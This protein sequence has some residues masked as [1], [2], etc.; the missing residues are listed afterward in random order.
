MERQQLMEGIRRGSAAKMAAL[1][2]SIRDCGS[3]LVAFSAGVDSSFVLAVARRVLG[4]RAV[5]LTAHSPSVPQVEREEARALARTLGVRHL[6]VESHEAEDPRYA[7]NPVD[8]CYYCKSELYRLC[9]AAAREHGLAAVLDGFNADDKR[10]HRPGHVA[11]SEHRVRSPLAEAGFT[12][13]EVRAWSEALG[14]PTWDKPQMACL[15]SRLPYGLAVTPERL[16]QVERAEA[17]VRAL[18]LKNFRVRYHEGIG[19]VEVAADEL[20]RAFELR[21][22]LA[23][24]VKGAGFKRAVLDLEPFRSGSLNEFAGVSLPVVA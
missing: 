12:K 15:A 3:A 19:R 23:G 11:A 9:D 16:A 5:A 10:D 21:A 6:E 24:A 8:R 1:E 7:A 14:L 17:G 13:D 4:E 18:G 20:A 2:Q 22:E